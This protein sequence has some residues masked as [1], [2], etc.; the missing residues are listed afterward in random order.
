M[1]KQTNVVKMVKQNNSK[2][3]DVN[4]VSMRTLAWHLGHSARKTSLFEMKSHSSPLCQ[5]GGTKQKITLNPWKKS[6][7]NN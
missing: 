7:K 3:T 4:F 6:N 2:Y 5:R 1:L